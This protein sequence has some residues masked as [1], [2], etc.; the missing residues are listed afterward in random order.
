MHSNMKGAVTKAFAQLQ[1]VVAMMARYAVMEKL[2][3][4][5]GDSISVKPEYQNSLLLLCTTMLHYFDA[6]FGLASHIVKLSHNKSSDLGS[7][8][9]ELAHQETM[10]QRCEELMVSIQEQDQKCQGFKVVVETEH[11][12]EKQSDTSDTE[13]E[14]VE[15]E[16][17]V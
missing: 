9:Q 15:S 4:Q 7:N 1:N 12:S 8:I 11:I 10:L 16:D 6:A 13:W 3:I 2:Y 5:T 14:A 17:D